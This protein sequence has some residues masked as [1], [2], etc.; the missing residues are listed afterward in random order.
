MSRGI[1]RRSERWPA[2]RA[3]GFARFLLLKG[4]LLRGGVMLAALVIMVT[5]KLGIEHP[6][7][8]LLIALAAVLCAIGGAVWAGLT[9]WLNERILR[10]LD[11][12]RQDT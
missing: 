10:S 5:L 7:L 3:A 6:R 8:P 2:I 9:W 1:A 12:F 4:V 11:T